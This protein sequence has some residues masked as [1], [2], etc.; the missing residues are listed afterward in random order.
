MEQPR[1]QPEH[2]TE[3]FSQFSLRLSGLSLL[4]EHASLVVDTLT[5]T[6]TLVNWQEAQFLDVIE[7]GDD[8][9]FALVF[10]LLKRWPSYVPYER[11]L[12][13]LGIPLTDQ[14]LADLE[15]LHTSGWANEPEGEQAQDQLAHERLHPALQTLRDLV[16]ECRPSLQGLGLDVVVVEGYGPLLVPLNGTQPVQEATKR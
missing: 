2:A 13:Q 7:F 1:Q 12:R 4:P 14:V 15:R 3:R 8:E 6:I 9:Q 10:T 11:L 16:E 5:G